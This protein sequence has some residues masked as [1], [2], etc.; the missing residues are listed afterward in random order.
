VRIGDYVRSFHSRFPF[1][2]PSILPWQV[3]AELPS[4]LER[5]AASLDDT[6]FRRADGMLIHPTAIIEAGAIVKPPAVILEGCFVAS[7][8]YL[9]GGSFLDRGVTVGPGCELKTA[10]IMAGSTLAHFNFVGDSIV[11]ADVNV[12]AGAVV[13]N[14]HNE[15]DDKEVRLQ[16]RGQEI[17]SGVHKFGAVIGD[18]CRLG[19]NAVLS[20]GTVL[21]PR[22]IVGRLTLIDQATG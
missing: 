12:E 17:R 16:V 15:R 3:T 18:H 7:T 1:L 20:P 2:D 13:A 5:L 21:E 11:G 8:A 9:R 14:H 19:A 6:S 22:A 10:V 4:I